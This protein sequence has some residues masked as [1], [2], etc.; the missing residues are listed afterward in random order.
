M[1]WGSINTFEESR[2]QPISPFETMWYGFL[3]HP[4]WQSYY[5]LGQINSGIVSPA[6]FPCSSGLP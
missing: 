5:F 4:F 3:F 6:S 2:M 1:I